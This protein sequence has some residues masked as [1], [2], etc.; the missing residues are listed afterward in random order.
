MNHGG[1]V[2]T[3]TTTS[4]TFNILVYLLDSR[5][6][7]KVCT[8]QYMFMEYDTPHS[9]LQHTTNKINNEN[10]SSISNQNP[11]TEEAALETE[12]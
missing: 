2:G 1:S 9:K 4:T 12:D 10:K 6:L 3:I 8:V 7:V 11:V 5:L